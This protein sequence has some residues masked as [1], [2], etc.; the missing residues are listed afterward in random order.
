M[1]KTDMVTW[2]IPDG[3]DVTGLPQ[4][5]VNVTSFDVLQLTVTKTALSV[6]GN[7]AQVTFNIHILV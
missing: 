4:T 2:D 6:F 3:E 1:H 7:L 5:V